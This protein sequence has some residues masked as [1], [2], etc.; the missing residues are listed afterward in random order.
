MSINANTADITI[1]STPR[2]V[3]CT[4]TQRTLDKLGVPYT[5]VDLS[6][7]DESRSA[8]AALGYTQAPV[9]IHGDTHWSGFRPDLLQASA[10][11]L[12][13]A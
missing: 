12:L 4:A 7:D 13:A 11:R 6:Q 8:V 2:C 10:K 5:V 1:Y 9:V 3:Q